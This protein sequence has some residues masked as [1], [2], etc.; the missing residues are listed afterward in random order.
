MG[1]FLR[2]TWYAAAWADEL[3]DKPLA[4]TLLGEPIVMFRTG[5]GVAA[6]GDRCAH[7]FAPLHLGKV[8]GDTLQCPYHGLRYDSSGQ[9]IH[10]PHGG[11]KPLA[12]AKV[13]S[14]P[15]IERYG[16][17]WIW[18]GEPAAA[19]VGKI[20]DFGHLID[21]K[22]YTTVPGSYLHIAANYELVADNLLDL[23]HVEFLHPSSF[24][25]DAISSGKHDVLVEGNT[26]YSNLLC[27]SV[28][29]PPRL[30][31]V[32]PTEGKPTDYS[33]NMRWDPPSVMRLDVGLVLAGL[34]R[35]KGINLLATHIV[36]PE[37][38]S[39]THYFFTSSRNFRMTDEDFSRNS[40]AAVYAIFEREDKQ[41]LEAQQQMMGT[42]DLWQLSPVLLATDA[43]AV[44]ARR[45]LA[46]L[47][48][49][50]RAQGLN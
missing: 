38:E 30:A 11:G 47:I 22:S 14:Y 42:T 17:V 9:C 49:S 25:T 21:S 8:I 10:N 19:D 48:E 3:A 15:V 26:V 16:L 12:A 40:R 4:R 18:L 39:A 41:M 46:R 32:Y 45:L 31:A 36:T 27:S 2:N 44:R 6:L 33:L 23:S 43:A 7:R 1:S 20:P 13:P 29:A 5:T 34:P 28:A 35:E 24:G 37:T 50:E